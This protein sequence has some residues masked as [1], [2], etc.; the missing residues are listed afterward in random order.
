MKVTVQQQQ[1]AGPL[2]PPSV[3]QQFD[4]LVDNGA[5]R[6]FAAWEGE[7]AHRQGMERRDLHASIA[8]G[9]LG[10]ILAFLFVIAVLALAAY[11]IYAKETAW[12]IVLGGGIIIAVV[13]AFIQTNRPRKDNAKPKA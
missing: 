8:E 1:W 2:P 3:L 11:A 9:L 7:T 13:T 4:D 6:I 10:K 5:E 12:G